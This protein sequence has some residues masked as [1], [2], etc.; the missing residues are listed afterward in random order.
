[1][2][3]IWLFRRKWDAP[4]EFDRLTL[5]NELTDLNSEYQLFD[6]SVVPQRKR[7]REAQ[8]IL[9]AHQ[10]V[11]AKRKGVPLDGGQSELDLTPVL[12]QVT[13]QRQ[14]YEEALAVVHGQI[15]QVQG[16]IAAQ[17][18]E[19][20]TQEAQQQQARQE[21][22]GLEADL[23]QQQASL[24]QLWGKLNTYQELLQPTNETL[25]ALEQ[26][27]QGLQQEVDRVQELG[28]YQS[29][30]LAEMNQSLTELAA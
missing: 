18:G 9:V 14:V 15:D 16:Q 11:L 28:G 24:A 30:L 27:L 21:I 4:N 1:M 22:E 20:T 12:D 8:A 13:A 5:E 3:P 25:N 6:E 19:I 26:Q 7:L 2:P 10:S 23:R 17:E 29:Q